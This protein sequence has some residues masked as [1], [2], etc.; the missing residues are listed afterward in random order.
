[1]RLDVVILVLPVERVAKGVAEGVPDVAL[2]VLFGLE[3]WVLLLH[4]VLLSNF[5]ELDYKTV[6]SI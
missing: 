6:V 2:H 5:L 4:V 1:V 3:R